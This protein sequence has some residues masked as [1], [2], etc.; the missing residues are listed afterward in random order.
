MFA[1]DLFF[2]VLNACGAMALVAIC[3]G[4]IERLRWQANTKR[5]AQG[6][7]F[8]AGA[9]AAIHIAAELL[10]GYLVDARS[11]FVG[12]AGAFGGWPS[13]LVSVLLAGAARLARGG[14]GVSA[15]LLAIPTAAI[16]GVGWKRLL[17][18]R[19]ARLPSLALLGLG[20]SGT[21]LFSPLFLPISLI[22][23]MWPNMAL[24][25]VSNVALALVLGSFIERERRLIE[26]EA[27]L[28]EEARSDSLTGL[29][30]RRSFEKTARQMLL[31]ASPEMPVALLAMDLDHFKDVNDRYGHA[32]GDEV[33]KA[34]AGILAQ[35]V[36]GKGAAGRL[37]GEE[38]GAVLQL[39][40][41]EARALAKSINQS[42][43]E[44]RILFGS[45]PVHVTISV[46][47]ATTTA[48]SAFDVVQAQ[49]DRALYA[50]KRLGR[51]RVEVSREHAA[52]NAA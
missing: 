23:D 37:G 4:Q 6:F 13:A 42:I 8:G 52:Q 40:A 15:A 32:F 10:P 17:G 41:L 30:N 2:A 27:Q 3:F 51:N 48:M 36:S 43:D 44:S 22:L 7:L 9:A 14:D 45:T 11:I 16:V 19:L 26:R 5:I 34:T 39:S 38:F 1:I 33:L 49:A 46:G 28:F 50:A 20:V 25:V 18:N 29:P 24:I 12:F 31:T 47:L 21:L 35:A